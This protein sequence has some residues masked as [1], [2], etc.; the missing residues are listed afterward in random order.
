MEF[1]RERVFPLDFFLDVGRQLG[2]PLGTE[3]GRLPRRRC[4]PISPWSRFLGCY[5]SISG[6]PR[7]CIFVFSCLLRYTGFVLKVVQFL[8]FRLLLL[9][10]TGDVSGF[11]VRTPAELHFFWDGLAGCSE[12]WTVHVIARRPFR[13]PEVLSISVFEI[14]FELLGQPIGHY[15]DHLRRF[16]NL[17]V[18][19]CDG[20]LRSTERLL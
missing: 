14:F 4:L 19:R 5:F 6:L 11:C 15:L 2:G 16:Q 8:F 20:K 7:Y 9:W 12:Q 18:V 13:H 1:L 17:C 3:L 10:L